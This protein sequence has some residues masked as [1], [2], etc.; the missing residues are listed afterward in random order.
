MTSGGQYRQNVHGYHGR[1][2]CCARPMQCRQARYIKTDKSLSQKYQCG[3]CFRW[4]SL[5]FNQDGTLHADQT[6]RTTGC[7]KRKT[8]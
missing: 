7:I 1:P 6:K 3:W 2:M 5:Y 4:I 8:H